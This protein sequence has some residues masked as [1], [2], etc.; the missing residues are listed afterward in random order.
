MAAPWQL[1]NA[2][3][4]PKKYGPRPII[5]QLE[6]IDIADLCRLNVFPRNWHTSNYLEMPFRYPFLRNL[7]ISLETIEANHFSGYIQSILLR[8]VRTGFGGSVRR[9]PLFI[10]QCG[11]SVRRVYFNHGFL[12]CRRCHDATYASRVCSKRQRPI[13]KAIRLK[14][15]LSLKSYMSQSNRNRLKAR[16]PTAQVQELKSKRLAHHAIQHPQHNYGTRGAM[17]W[18]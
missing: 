15:F 7:V 3:R 18:R 9:R 4:R 13:L 5:E 10:C 12:A 1:R 2:K 17:H 16:I 14:A 6:R 11:K 8:W